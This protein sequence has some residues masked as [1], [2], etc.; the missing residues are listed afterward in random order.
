MF[1]A[2]VIE[3]DDAGYRAVVKTV[4]DDSLPAVEGG[5]RSP[6]GTATAV[7]S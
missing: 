3:K 5:L 7:G 2:L 1:R 6:A 4:G